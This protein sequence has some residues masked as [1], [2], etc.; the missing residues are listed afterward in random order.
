MKLDKLRMIRNE[1][2]REFEN[3]TVSSTVFYR[4]AGK[5]NCLDV[6]E[7]VPDAVSNCLD[8]ADSDSIAYHPTS[9]RSAWFAC[10]AMNCSIALEF[11]T[12]P[13]PSH[14]QEMQGPDRAGTYSRF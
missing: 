2:E 3:D 6:T 14:S 12:S 13:P 9:S 4:H 5:W 7:T 1:L 10:H 11:S 8:K